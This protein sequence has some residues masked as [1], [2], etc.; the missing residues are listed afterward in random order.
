M[1]V[2][3]LRHLGGPTEERALGQV[4]ASRR[5]VVPSVNS[6]AQFAH[7]SGYNPVTIGALKAEPGSALPFAS[8]SIGD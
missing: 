7:F 3:S 8:A 5:W 4:A 1:C 6:I 2:S